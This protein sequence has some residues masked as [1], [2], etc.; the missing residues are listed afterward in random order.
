M[1][2]PQKTNSAAGQRKQKI[3]RHNSFFGHVAMDRRHMMQIME[4]ETT[5]PESRA[6]AAEV[7]EKLGHLARSLKT[8]NRDFDQKEP[9]ND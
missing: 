5:S 3:W 7:H 1:K 4:A 8:R 9:S 6:I 2:K